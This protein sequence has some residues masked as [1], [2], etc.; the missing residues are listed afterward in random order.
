MQKIKSFLARR[1]LLLGLLLTALAAAA[2]LAWAGYDLAGRVDDQPVYEIVND[3]YTR[4]V[5]IPM[6]SGLD[7]TISLA[8]G[9]RI[10]GVRLDV[11]TFNYA[12]SDGALHADLYDDTGALLAAGTQ[13]LLGM[14]DNTFTGVIFAAPYTAAEASTLR[15]HIW[16]EGGAGHPLG[17]WASESAVAGLPLS[18]DT[19]ALNATAALQFVTDYS[20]HWSRTL[21]LILGVLLLAAVVLG[22]ALLFI[23]RARLWIVFAVEALLLGTA[24]A[25]VTPPLVAP[26]EY[27]HLAASYQ[28]ASRLLG[29][30]TMA[31]RNDTLCMVVRACDAPYFKDRTGDIGVF[32]YKQMLEHMG[33]AGQPGAC[34]T[35]TDVPLPSVL[36]ARQYGG[37]T[38]GIALARL[39]GLG[40]FGMLLLGRLGN[41]LVYVFL[42]G[43]AVWLAP[44]RLRGLF[45]CVGLLPMA[46]QLTG[47]LS[48]D[49]IVLGL[50][51]CYTALCLALREHKARRG[52]LLLL[53]LLAMNIGPL[54][55]IYLPMA[56]LCLLIP[57]EHLD[58]RGEEA[59]RARPVWRFSVFGSPFALNPGALVKAG[60]LALATLLWLTANGSALLYATRDVDNVGLTRAAGVVVLAVAALAAVYLKARRTPKGKRFFFGA[61]IAL[62]VLA[63]PVAL[64]KLTHMWGGL[65]PEALVGSVQANGDSIY[66]YSAGYI[67]RNLPGTLK[68]LLRSV[69]AQGALW[70]QGVLGTALGE[71]IVYPVMVS[72]VLG[73]GLV[74]ALLAAALPR[75]GETPCLDRRARW[76]TGFVMLAVVGLSV[77]AALSWT[78]INYQTIFG[79]Q[80]RYWLPALPL[81]LLLVRQTPVFCAQRDTARPAVFGIVC[82]NALV[83]LQGYGIYAAFEI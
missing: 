33:D 57:S 37:Q 22:F 18:G 62:A 24:F 41:L 65:T 34:D 83:L 5:E 14:K 81:A 13:E 4:T 38:L 78:P 70:L 58:I 59:L 50:A 45:G 29:Q 32:A 48:G 10:Y 75:A 42:A 77:L 17:L 39:L 15:L 82:L 79:L 73:L 2:V 31:E 76:G 53:L 25:F 3:D 35:V 56:L 71:P 11:A 19:G 54:K 27:T 7:Q 49:G 64:Y 20:G 6:N 66:T 80:G 51:F 40:F 26:D 1:R 46:A 74:L 60:A 23:A 69:S 9:Q 61:L 52:E 36:G 21:S 68:L 67:C 16:Y 63:V 43:L 12:F 30:P 8:A 72:W 55:A 44:K 28:Q 47:S